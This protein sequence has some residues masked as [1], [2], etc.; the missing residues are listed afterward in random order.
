[1]YRN[2]GYFPHGRRNVAGKIPVIKLADFGVSSYCHVKHHG[3]PFRAEWATFERRVK[4]I[5]KR[6][7]IYKAIP[8]KR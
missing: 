4:I 6:T 5:S 3:D 1:M 7:E 8:Q 2:D